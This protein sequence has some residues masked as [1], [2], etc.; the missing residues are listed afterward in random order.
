M[1]HHGALLGEALHVLRL[2]A[3]VGLG[4]EQGEVGVHVAGGF[5]AP[6]VGFL[7]G[8]PDGIAVGPD[9]HGPLH[10]AVVGQL[11]LPDHVG[12]P[13]GVVL[14]ARCDAFGH[15]GGI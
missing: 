8:L 9:D 15:G 2:T 11:R 6:V 12:V 13:A 1:G 5:E 7:D 4:D 10:R 3:E 14:A